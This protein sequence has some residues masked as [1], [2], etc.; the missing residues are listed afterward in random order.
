MAQMTLLLENFVTLLRLGVKDFERAQPQRVRVT[1]R[2]QLRTIPTEDAITAT[3]DYTQIFDI[4]KRMGRTHHDLVEHFA[5][6]F[7]DTLLSDARLASVEIE[8]LKLDAVAGAEVGARY[9]AP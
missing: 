7:A 9:Q 1:V 5:V 2:A 8:L 3:Y 4:V 6:A